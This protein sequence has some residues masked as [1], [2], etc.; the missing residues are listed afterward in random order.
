MSVFSGQKLRNLLTV[1]A[2]SG[3]FLFFSRVNN[4]GATL[5]VSDYLKDY[6]GTLTSANWNK[7]LGYSATT[8]SVYQGNVPL[9]DFLPTGLAA[10]MIGPLGI[11]V[12]P[13]TA[14]LTVKADG[15]NNILSLLDSSGVEKLS[16]T[17]AGNLGLGAS[18]QSERLYISGTITNTLATKH[19]LLGGAGNVLVMADTT[20]TLYSTTTDAIITPIVTTSGGWTASGTTVYKTNTSGNVGIGT[21][22]PTQKLDVNGISILRDM[23][24]WGANGRTN[25][26]TGWFS[27]AATS[28]NK[29]YLGANG[30]ESGQ[31]VIDTNGNVGVGTTN[32]GAKLDVA[33]TSGLISRFASTGATGDLNYIDIGAR[34]YFGYDGISQNTVIQSIGG[35]GIEF[36]VN[37]GTFGSGEVMR[38]TS[39]GSV[40]IGTTDPGTKLDV[41]GSFRNTLSTTHS[42]LGGAGNVLVMADTTGTL[43]ATSTDILTPIVTTSGG[44]TANGTTVYKTD[45][46]GNVGVGTTNPTATF[47]VTKASGPQIAMTTAG[48]GTYL[49]GKRSAGTLVAPTAIPSANYNLLYMMGSG[50]GSTAFQTA[51]WISVQSAGAF[52][53][54]S[55]PGQI[56]FETTPVS[57]IASLERMRITSSGDVGIGTT[58]PGTKLDV[59]GS[60]R[61]TLATTHSL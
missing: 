1:L 27:L 57:A 39:A 51:G 49:I 38:I 42:L 24:Y 15:A 11:N 14:R 12:A 26:D 61:N 34:A 36:N 37:N 29:L 8:S 33:G 55:S 60:F 4:V 23:T 3:V 56:V 53:D 19:S 32:P 40:G 22:N 5:N 45:I 9:G 31:M 50:Y 30:V 44:W 43:Y 7:L 59:T 48:N 16:V 41:T 2:L 47:E 10:T 20:G 17:N 54:T 25:W 46:N 52:S 28:G 21:T 35:K 13:S 6:N 18:G 58:T